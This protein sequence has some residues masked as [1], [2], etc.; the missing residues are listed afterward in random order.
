MLCRS[1]LLLFV[2]F[3]FFSHFLAAGEAQE[4]LYIRRLAALKEKGENS[5]FEQQAVSFIQ[6]HPHS[7]Y[8]P[9]VRLMMA[10][11]ALDC[12]RE[13]EAFGLFSQLMDSPLKEKA[14]NGKLLIW[15]KNGQWTEIEK[16]LEQYKHLI[17][18]NL[19]ESLYFE[20]AVFYL[21]DK[22]KAL[23]LLT[24]EIGRASCRERVSSPV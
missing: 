17:S 20:A 12:A 10:E 11:E 8:L 14:I 19:K 6:E 21:E 23:K 24:R 4:A 3:Q 22:Q 9:Y 1:F 5:L 15:R 18:K 13:K 2:F 16:A 7:G